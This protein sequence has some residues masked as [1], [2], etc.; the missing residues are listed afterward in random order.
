MT[1]SSSNEDNQIIFK[2]AELDVKIR[3][4][5]KNLLNLEGHIDNVIKGDNRAFKYLIS[6]I[7]VVSATLIG[8]LG[9][10]SLFGYLNQF[11]NTDRVEKFVA[12]AKQSESDIKVDYDKFIKTLSGDSKPSSLKVESYDGSFV[13]LDTYISSDIPPRINYNLHLKVKAQGD[14]VAKYSGIYVEFSEEF[15]N[16]VARHN[17]GTPDKAFYS[18]NKG[19][20]TFSTEQEKIVT[21][22]SID[23]DITINS[24]SGTCPSLTARLN[25][26]KKVQDF[27]TVTLT[28]VVDT[29]GVQAQTSTYKI[30]STNYEGCFS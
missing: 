1:N 11:T 7:A 24:E 25:E 3:M 21:S 5:E 22:Y 13:S 28:P 4:V 2:V 20:T 29:V 14:G 6:F 17:D 10:F 16:A 12:E 9:V 23:Q 8:Y 15:L 18:N 26:L 19:G 27:G 30:V